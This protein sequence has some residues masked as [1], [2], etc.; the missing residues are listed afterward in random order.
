MQQYP[1][2]KQPREFSITRK[3]TGYYVAM[4]FHLGEMPEVAPID[5]ATFGGIDLGVKNRRVTH[6]V[7]VMPGRQ[8]D[9]EVSK[10]LLWLEN[11]MDDLRQEALDDGRAEKVCRGVSKKTGEPL[12]RFVWKSGRPSRSYL[13]AQQQKRRLLHKES[14]R[15]HNMLHRD[16][17]AMVRR[18]GGLAVEALGIRGMMKSAK[19]TKDDPGKK[20]AQKRGLNRSIGFQ[21][22]G[23]WRTQAKYKNEREGKPHVEVDPKNTSITCPSC[24]TVD[25]ASRP[26]R[27]DFECVGCGYRAN[28]DQNGAG[29]IR[30]KALA[31]SLPEDESI[32]QVRS[33]PSSP[34][35]GSVEPYVVVSDTEL[36]VRDQR[37]LALWGDS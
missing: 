36:R 12:F 35:A 28:A 11:R 29:N 7:D 37:Q 27:D 1:E 32:S 3:P 5:P 13:K 14:L 33:D 6:D 9:P 26:T 24:G 19:G 8:R 34:I 4:T 16:S 10:R 2:G 15:D 23:K 25:K 30:L 21:A 31:S 20:V 22:W 18:Y 17:T